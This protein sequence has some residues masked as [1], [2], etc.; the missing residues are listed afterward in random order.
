[1]ISDED[2]Y[3]GLIDHNINPL[4]PGRNDGMTG[5]I[6]VYQIE[7]DWCDMVS[8]KR[9]E[10]VDKFDLKQTGFHLRLMTFHVSTGYVDCLVHQKFEVPEHLRDEYLR[11]FDIFKSQY[12]AEKSEY[13]EKKEALPE[14]I[15][16]AVKDCV[17]ILKSENNLEEFDMN[18]DFFTNYV[19]EI[20]NSF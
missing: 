9:E 12:E 5:A 4:H 11:R 8:C 15:K 13:E 18:V 6:M 19:S 10:P 14:E 2:F 20:Y 3:Q 7:R 17:R 1:M 16:N